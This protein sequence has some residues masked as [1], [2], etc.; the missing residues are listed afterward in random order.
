MA[1][2]TYEDFA[3][4]IRNRVIREGLHTALPCTVTSV[5]FDS[6]RGLL[7]SVQPDVAM[8]FTADTGLDD[9][10]AEPTDYVLPPVLTEVP[11]CFTGAGE[12]THTVPVK[13][14]TTGFLL[15]M[16]ASLDEWLIT[17][18]KAQ[19]ADP[20]RF[21]LQDAVFLPQ[22]RRFGAASQVEYDA[23]VAVL[24]GAVHKFGS[25]S[26]ARALARAKETADELA[27]LYARVEALFDAVNTAFGLTAAAFA[28]APGGVPL[29]VPALG[30]WSALAP[31]GLDPATENDIKAT[32]ILVEE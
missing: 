19:P 3:D 4:S 32:N 6:E 15:C 9:L 12:Y 30:L 31:V 1:I 11:V 10:D 27:D 23:D 8:P 2:E 22:L 25:A 13:A 14:G 24:S 16:E 28:P 17:T 18:G 20:R 5:E 7:V 29:P 21:A 26:A